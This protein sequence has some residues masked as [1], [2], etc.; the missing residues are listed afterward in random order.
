MIE[1]L[2]YEAQDNGSFRGTINIKMHKWG[3]FVLEGIALM[4]KGTAR[5]IKAPH[6]KIELSGEV[7]WVPIFYFESSEINKKFSEEVWKAFETWKTP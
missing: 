1:I 4:Q 6:K 3:G 5:W 7:K 2:H